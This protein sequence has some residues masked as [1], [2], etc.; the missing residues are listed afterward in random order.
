MA[1]NQVMHNAC[2]YLFC[3]L[4]RTSRWFAAVDTWS[5]TLMIRTDI[6]IGIGYWHWQDPAILSIGWLS[7]YHSSPS[8]VIHDRISPVLSPSTTMN[9][10]KLDSV[11]A[12]R[13]AYSTFATLTTGSKA[14]LLV[15]MISICF[16]VQCLCCLSLVVSFFFVCHQ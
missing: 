15:R 1:D 13:V 8:C 4:Y 3:P 14:W 9:G 16:V 11:N 10:K 12:L 7:W 6:G 2:N 5:R